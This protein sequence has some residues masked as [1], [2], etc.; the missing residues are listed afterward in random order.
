MGRHKPV[1]CL[2]G[3]IEFVQEMDDMLL[4]EL[5]SLFNKEH[6]RGRILKDVSLVIGSGRLQKGLR[7]QGN[8]VRESSSSQPIHFTT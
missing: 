2:V 5:G 6:G 1:Y 4:F 8:R 3:R 7:L